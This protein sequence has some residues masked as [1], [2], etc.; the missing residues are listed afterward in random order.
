MN[1]FVAWVLMFLGLIVT[2]V[3]F[4]SDNFSDAWYVIYTLFD[5]TNLQWDDLEYTSSLQKKYI[6]VALALA[7]LFKNSI[8][9]SKSFKPDFKYTSYTIILLT[10]SLLTFVKAKEF[11]YFQF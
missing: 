4:V 5:F 7:L 10:A 6:I 1:Y 8:E 11:L 3:L 9:I 2:R